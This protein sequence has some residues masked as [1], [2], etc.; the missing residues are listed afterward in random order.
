M[1]GNTKKISMSPVY[2]ASKHTNIASFNILARSLENAFYLLFCGGA[3]A[4]RHDITKKV[5][6]TPFARDMGGKSFAVCRDLL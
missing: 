2:G 6:N 4:V 3:I 5:Y 1:S